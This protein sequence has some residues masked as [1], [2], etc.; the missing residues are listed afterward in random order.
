MQYDAVAIIM[1]SVTDTPGT[2]DMAASESINVF[3]PLTSV[4][5]SEYV[6]GLN[7]FNDALEIYNGSGSEVDLG[8][9]SIDKYVNA[10][11]TTYSLLAGNLAAGEVYVISHSSASSGIRSQADARDVFFNFN[12]RTRFALLHNGAVVDWIGSVGNAIPPVGGWS[13]AGTDNAATNHTLVRKQDVFN[14]NPIP[15]RSFGTNVDDSEWIVYDVDEFSYL[16][17][18]T[19]VSCTPSTQASSVVFGATDNTSMEV[20]WT[21]GAG[22]PSLVVVKAGSEVDAVPVFGADYTS[23]TTVFSPGTVTLGDNVVVYSEELETVTVT[24]LTP[25][26]TYYVA[27]YAYNATSFCYNTTSP[28]RGSKATTTPNDADSD[29]TRVG[30]ETAE[31]AYYGL[32]T[33]SDLTTANS[34]S[35]FTFSINDKGQGTE[36]LPTTVTAISFEITNHQYLRTLAL[37]DGTADGADLIKELEVTG[38]TP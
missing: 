2:L 27:V 6:E 11:P 31:I 18:H 26:I 30:G 25:G 34:A 38:A 3:E 9:F 16:G 15:L 1:L 22:Y 37:F 20:N 7:E 24:D 12:G 28:A 29:I 10:S 35:L 21:K 33:A 5:F 8:E 19:Q 32:Q 13:V 17:S 23:A 14:G 4:F 36:A